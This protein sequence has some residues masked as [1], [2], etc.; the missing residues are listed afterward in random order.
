MYDINYITNTVIKGDCQT[1][2][3]KI[4]NESIDCIVIDPP[5]R[6]L[7]HRLDRDFSM[8]EKSF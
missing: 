4:E 6:Y 1:E 8:Q 5:Y 2:L 7:N 3:E